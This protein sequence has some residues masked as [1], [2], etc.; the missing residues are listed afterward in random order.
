ME[1]QNDHDSSGQPSLQDS[2][3]E[4]ELEI[5]QHLLVNTEPVLDLHPNREN[6]EREKTVL[7]GARVILPLAPEAIHSLLSPS[8]ATGAKAVSSHKQS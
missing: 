4:E 2:L 6:L 5:S 8:R 3:V 7:T 1:W